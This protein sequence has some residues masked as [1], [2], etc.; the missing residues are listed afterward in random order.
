MSDAQPRPAGNGISDLEVKDGQIIFPDRQL[1]L[2]ASDIL[3][4]QR[5]A[6]VRHPLT[7]VLLDRPADVL[8]KL[9]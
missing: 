9:P 4:R 1:M 8:P 3:K 5:G 7:Q 6:T 2:F